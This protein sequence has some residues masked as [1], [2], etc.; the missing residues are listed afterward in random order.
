MKLRKFCSCW[1]VFDYF[2][3]KIMGVGE[4]LLNLECSQNDRNFPTSDFLTHKISDSTFFRTALSNY[5]FHGKN[6]SIIKF[7][8]LGKNLLWKAQN[9]SLRWIFDPG[10]QNHHFFFEIQKFNFSDNESFEIAKWI[11]WFCQVVNFPRRTSAEDNK[12][13]DKKTVGWQPFT[14]KEFHHEHILNPLPTCRFNFFTF[15]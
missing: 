4:L 9:L 8:K 2:G 3:K 11:I 12:F 13:W 14:G 7:S 15:F 10:S 6:I 1:K 5:T